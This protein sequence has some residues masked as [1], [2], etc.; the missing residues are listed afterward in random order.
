[1]LNELGYCCINTELGKL[2]ISTNRTMT[3][4]TFDQKGLSYVSELAIQNLRDLKKILEWN[5]INNIFNFRMSSEI[6]S[7]MSEYEFYQLPKYDLICRLCD[8]IGEYVKENKIRLTFHPG[9]YTVIA[10]ENLNVIQN[11][12]LDLERHSEIMNMMNLSDSPYNCINIHLN[13]TKPNKSSVFERFCN[14]YNQLKNETKNRLTIENDDKKSQYHTKDLYELHQMCGVPI[15][16]DYHHEKIHSS[17]LSE[18]ESLTLA[19]S[20]WKNIKPLC[21][22]SESRLIEEVGVREQAHSD[23]IYSKINTYNLEFD[24]DIEAKMKEQAL[25][26]YRKDWLN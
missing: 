18:L 8:G 17:D 12:I 4:K 1:M 15:V 25:L 19:L 11:S 10:S 9:P 7:W 24:I 26:K 22:Y 6:F 3:R 14:S 5:K 21:H 13:S 16:F 2:K 20:T 23:Y